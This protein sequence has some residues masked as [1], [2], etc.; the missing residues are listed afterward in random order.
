MKKIGIV[1]WNTGENSFGVTKTYLNY[2]S[3]FGRIRII[4]PQDTI[5]D[6]L[7]LDLLVL[8][9]GL[10]VN[11]TTYG[12]V[13]GFYTSNQDVMKQYFYDTQLSRYIEAKIPIFGICLG[14][15]M[16][17]VKFGGKLNQ[18]VPSHSY[19]D[20]F[21]ENHKINISL[22]DEDNK[23]FLKYYFLNSS[24]K[25]KS[26]KIKVTGISVNSHHHQTVSSNNI[27]EDLIPLA[28]ADDGVI[29]SFIHKNLPI[30]GVQFHPEEFN[31]SLS[32][33]LIQ[34]LLNGSKEIR[35]EQTEVQFATTVSS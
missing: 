11:P 15:Q 26:G 19:A 28:Y 13:P 31:V 17:N 6:N 5:K 32:N 23:K 25:T 20:R 7:D 9:G 4:T 1:G 22:P 8:P 3:Q 21:E 10:D 30:A 35:Q 14:F 29:E 16:L 18:H 33:L 27:A 34:Y 2:L 12:A 24:E